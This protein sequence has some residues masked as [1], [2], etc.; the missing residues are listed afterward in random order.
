MTATTDRPAQLAA[1]LTDHMVSLITALVDEAQASRG[2]AENA[3]AV[4]PSQSDPVFWTVEQ[5]AAEVG[6]SVTKVRQLTRD[7]VIPAR[8]L[9]HKWLFI[10]A[11]VRAWA[12][13]LP[14]NQS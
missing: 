4:P 6:Y 1:A 3:S 7:G 13:A 10:P 8:K 14:G 12:A 11:E 5:V 2:T 9:D